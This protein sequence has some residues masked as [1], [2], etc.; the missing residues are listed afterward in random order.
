MKKKL[1]IVG[2]GRWGATILKTASGMPSLDLAAA[3]TSRSLQELRE[4]APFHGAVLERYEELDSLGGLDGVIIATPPEGRERIICHF[5]DSGVPVFAEKPLTLDVRQTAELVQKARKSG[6]PLVEDFIHL[7]SWAYIAISENLSSAGRIEIEATAGNDGPRRDYSPVFDYGPHD[8]AMALQLFKRM[9]QHLSVR[10]QDRR[11]ELEFS[12]TVDMDFGSRGAASLAF[13]NVLAE[14]QRVF[15]CRSGRDEWIYDDLA[16]DKLSKNGSPH[17]PGGTL[18]HYS[19]L[20][21]ALRNFIGEHSLYSKDECLWLS[22]S[23]AELTGEITD[24]L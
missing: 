5:L 11:S 15:V 22:K 9:P 18:Q 19:P 14:K 13:S 21:L 3:V 8:L 4:I 12:T 10:V 1:A 17:K 7:Y 6:V 23:V 2:V 16:Q 24:R 20:Q